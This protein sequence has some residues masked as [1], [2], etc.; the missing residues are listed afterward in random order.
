LISPPQGGMQMPF[1]APVA[2]PSPGVPTITFKLGRWHRNAEL[3]G[4]TFE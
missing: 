4:L 1:G 2:L 3:A